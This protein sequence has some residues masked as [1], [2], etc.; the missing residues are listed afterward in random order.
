[1]V[2]KGLIPTGIS[3][4]ADFVF[5]LVAYL[6]YELWHYL[7]FQVYLHET[8]DNFCMFLWWHD[9]IIMGVVLV[10]VI[11]IY[12]SVYFSQVQINISTLPYAFLSFKIY[13]D[14]TYLDIAPC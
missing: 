14:E 5:P 3:F 8:I 7:P 4:F 13:T 12:L 2:Y 11:F 1:M 10:C 6:F 9:L